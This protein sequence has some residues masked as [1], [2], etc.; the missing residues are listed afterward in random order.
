MKKELEEEILK[1]NHCYVEKWEDN[2][3]HE[4]DEFVFD[5]FC[6]NHKEI[7]IR[8][9]ERERIFKKI[10]RQLNDIRNEYCG[11]CSTKF[12]KWMGKNE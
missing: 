6:M 2:I 9:N 12:F 5:N 11:E 10:K 8:I 4:K 1:C 7:L 3:M